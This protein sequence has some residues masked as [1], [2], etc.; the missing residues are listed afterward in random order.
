MKNHVRNLT[1]S[2]LAFTLAPLAQAN[3][4]TVF[5]STTQAWSNTSSISSDAG[6][7]GTTLTTASTPAGTFSQ[8]ADYFNLASG[9]ISTGSGIWTLTTT[10]TFNVANSA[11]GTPSQYISFSAGFGNFTSTAATQIP[12]GQV[13]APTI[14][15]P[16][17][18]G[19]PFIVDT[20]FSP[21][22]SGPTGLNYNGTL[23]GGVGAT[24]AQTYNLGTVDSGTHMPE[25]MHQA[26]PI[27]FKLVLDTTNP[28]WIASL[29]IDGV[30][31]Q[32]TDYTSVSAS[33]IGIS[34]ISGGNAHSASVT[35]GPTL[36]TDDVTSA[37]PEPSTWAMMV[38]GFAGLGFMAYRRKNRTGELNF[39]VA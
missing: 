33:G 11:S 23:N 2:A 30:L 13:G 35:F 5:D 39:R 16:N 15:G 38:L 20:R 8:G 27:T 17:G 28:D 37:V 7:G 9:A 32:T 4:T 29:Y 14:T 19:G 10:A 22:V 12:I 24:G 6:G 18:N 1:M 26:A 36:L 25:Y 31:T 21:S 3:A 34:A